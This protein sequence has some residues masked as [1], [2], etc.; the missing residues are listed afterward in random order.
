[1]RVARLRRSTDIAKVRSEGRSLRREGFSARARRADG[2]D[3]RIAVS[4]S[5]ALGGAVIRSRAKR[6]VREAFR[7]A[8]ASR[9]SDAG[10]DLVITPRPEALKT[11]FARLR[12]DAAAVLDEASR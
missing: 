4:A 6:R 2:R 3:V 12:A 8:A 9:V 10:L 1:V 11:A 7:L 5:R